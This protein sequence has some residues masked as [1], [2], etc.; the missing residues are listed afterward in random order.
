[1]TFF[2][3]FVLL[4]MEHVF[5]VTIDPCSLLLSCM[6]NFLIRVI[7]INSIIK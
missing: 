6:Y 5:T 1:M 7:D 3:E 4:F 2:E